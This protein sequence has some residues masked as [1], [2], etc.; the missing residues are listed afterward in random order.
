MCTVCRSSHAVG[1]IRIGLSTQSKRKIKEKR[2]KLLKTIS[3]VEYDGCAA[4][5]SLPLVECRYRPIEPQ[6][7]SGSRIRRRIFVR[8]E[9]AETSGRSIF[10]LFY[11]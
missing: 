7:V 6:A 4:W 9:S 11:L 2:E 10:F 3:S 1:P 5:F 8:R